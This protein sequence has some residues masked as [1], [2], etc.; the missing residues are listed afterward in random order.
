[1]AA[2]YLSSV[3]WAN[4]RAGIQGTVCSAYRKRD[5]GRSTDAMLVCLF[6]Q[7]S[8]LS[9]EW[10]LGEDFTDF[11]TLLPGGFVIEC[12]LYIPQ[13]ENRISRAEKNHLEFGCGFHPNLVIVQ[14]D[15]PSYLF[16]N[17]SPRKFSSLAESEE[18]PV[19]WYQWREWSRSWG[20]AGDG[21]RMDTEFEKRLLTPR[22]NW[23]LKKNIFIS[24]HYDLEN[25]VAK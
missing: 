8:A 19:T 14:P 1:M 18:I 16:L 13:P 5:S 15:H 22:Y 12:K 17:P 2:L 11:P 25:V 20:V 9:G 24:S 6:G 3:L 7:M 21:V 10:N 23:A 4:Q